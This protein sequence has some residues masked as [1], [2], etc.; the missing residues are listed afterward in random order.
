MAGKRRSFSGEFKAKVAL[1]ALRGDRTVN[2]VA[3]HFEVHPLQVTKWKK[4]F[5]ERAPGVMED[6]RGCRK[7]EPP[8]NGGLVDELYREIGRLKVERDWLEK[9]AGSLDGG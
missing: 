6:R 3:A 1:A 4:Q 8:E 5:L 9:K 7:K 2:E